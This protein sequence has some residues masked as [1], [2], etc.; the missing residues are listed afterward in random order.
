MTLQ[1]IFK[2]VRF[3]DMVKYL[4]DIESQVFENLY[5]FKEAFDVLRMMEAKEGM[6]IPIKIEILKTAI[7]SHNLTSNILDSSIGIAIDRLIITT[8]I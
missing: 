2:S 6:N 4:I 8:L 7:L 3:E 1:E 5:C